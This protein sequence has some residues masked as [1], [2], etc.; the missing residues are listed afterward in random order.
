VQWLWELHQQ[1][2]GGLLGDEMGLGKTVQVI[3]FLTGLAVSR[4]H[5]RHG[6]FRGLGP[7]L[8]VCPTTLMMQWVAECHRWWPPFRVALLHLSGSHQGE[9]FL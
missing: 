4:L 1:R 3:G 6:D 8:I 7:V 2:C 9:F 5:S